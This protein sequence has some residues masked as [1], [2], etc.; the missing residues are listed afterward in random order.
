MTCIAA[1]AQDGHV[2]VGGDSAGFFGSTVYAVADGKVFRKGEFVIGC[3]GSHRFSNIVRSGFQPPSLDENTDLDGYMATSFVNTLRDALRASGHMEV[4][5]GVESVGSIMIVGLRGSLFL[6]DELF[7]TI[8]APDGI[9]AIGSGAEVA[10]GA[11]DATEGLTP[12]LSPED[13]IKRALAAA[14]R[15]ND[16][17]RAPFTLESL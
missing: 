8:R 4:F 1:I 16:S 15:R 7:A 13:R 3:A 6:V 10:L 5:S 9:M 17:V 14:E 11:L 12:D 2:Y